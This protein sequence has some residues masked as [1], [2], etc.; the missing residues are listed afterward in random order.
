MINDA[1]GLAPSQ[2]KA[3]KL[4]YVH[5]PMC[6]WC[7]AFSP[8]L[9]QIVQGLPDRVELVRLLGGLAP[10]S[11]EPMPEAMREF[12]QATWQE[13]I[14]RVPGTEFNFDFWSQCQPRRSTYPACRGVIAARMQ[15]SRYESS[16]IRAIQ[17]AYY[18]QAMNPSDDATLIVLA[19]ELRLDVEAF[20]QALNASATQQRL[21]QEIELGR[22]IGAEGFPS[23]ILDYEGQL[24]R[25]RYSYTDPAP[26]LG[27][28]GS[29]LGSD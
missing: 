17:Q 9:E 22:S 10:D 24:H 25:L 4:Y 26:V 29:L 15:G 3:A 6:S 23:L 12:L 21:L 11:S 16:M 8:V 19:R 28:I 1:T 5:D 13:I 27:R 2:L 14:E 20:S 18:L 7:W